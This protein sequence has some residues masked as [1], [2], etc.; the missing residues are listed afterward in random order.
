MDHPLITEIG[1][2]WHLKRTNN[3]WTYDLMYHL[4]VDLEKI[5]TLASMTDIAILIAYELN[6]GMK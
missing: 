5:I 4:M 3:K 1:F 2:C 6:L